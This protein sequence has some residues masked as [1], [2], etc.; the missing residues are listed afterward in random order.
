M[1]DNRDRVLQ[2]T[3]TTIL[4]VGLLLLHSQL[5]LCRPRM[6]FAAVRQ[7]ECRPSASSLNLLLLLLLLPLPCHN[8]GRRPGLLKRNSNTACLRHHPQCLL[9]HPQCLLPSRHHLHSLS[10]R[11]SPLPR[12]S[13]PKS[14]QGREQVLVRAGRLSKA[15]LASLVIAAALRTSRPLDT[16]WCSSKTSR[17]RNNSNSPLH[18]LC[19][20]RPPHSRHLHQSR[21]RKRNTL[22]SKPSSRPCWHP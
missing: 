7:A 8:L 2:A 5:L 21:K 14:I 4:D 17:H 19:H 16:L 3:T 6:G 20:H 12:W 9:H 1:L 13:C 22:S 18:C 10:S 11:V 15:C